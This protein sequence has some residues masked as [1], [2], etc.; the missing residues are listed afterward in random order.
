MCIRD[1]LFIEYSSEITPLEVELKHWV[2]CVNTRSQPVTGIESAKSVARVI[3][4]T[5]QL[6]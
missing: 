2:D 3:D 5:K 1:R 4:A 6:L